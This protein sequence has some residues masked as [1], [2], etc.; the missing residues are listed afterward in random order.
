MRYFLDTE[1]I[2]CAKQRRVLG[3]RIG[4]PVPTVDLISIALVAEDGREF[5]ALNADCELEYAWENKWVRDNVLL[6]IWMQH[7]SPGVRYVFVHFSLEEM[8]HIF[9][10]HGLK[11]GQLRWN[12]LTFCFPGAYEKWV[13]SMDEFWQM[14]K[15][16]RPE[17]YGYYAD[18]DWVVFCQLFG[19]MIDLPNGFPMYCRDLKQ[20]MDE[21]GM[22][23]DEKDALCPDPKDAHNALADARWNRDFHATLLE[24]KPATAP[25]PAA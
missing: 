20:L 18:Y 4:K 1:F 21:A 11:A 22:T 14:G 19:R 3:I 15:E 25:L 12:L 10:R 23:S 2:E 9:R 6:P 8:R 13:G 24:F 16:E 7:T 5:Y 17:F